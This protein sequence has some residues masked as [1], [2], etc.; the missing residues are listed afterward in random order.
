MPPDRCVEFIVDLIPGTTPI[1]RRPYR[2]APHELGELKTQLKVLLDKGLICPSSS[3]CGFPVLIVT[4]KDRTERM[5]VE[6]PRLNLAT[7]KSKYPLPRINDLYDQ[8]AGS[9]VF[10]KMDLRLGYHQIK[11]R[12]EDI[13]KTA[14]TTRYGLYEY[15]VMSFGLTNAP[16]TF[17]RL[18]NSIFMEYQDKFVVVYLD[19]ILIYSKN[20]EEHAEHLRLVLMKL[21]EHRLYAKF[22]KCEFWLPEVTYLGHVISAKAFAVNPERVQAV[23]DWTPPESVKQV[24]SFLGL[25]SYCRH[26]VENFSKVAK[27]LTELLQ[28]DKKFQW[29]PKREERFQELKRRLTSAPV[30]APPDTKWDF[31]IYCDSSRQGLGC[32]IMQDR[33]VVAYASRQLRPHEENYRTHDLELAVVVHALKTW[34][35][36]LLGNHCEIYSDHQ[37]LKYIF[38][39]PELNLR[40]RHWIELI[41]DYDVGISY[42]PG[43]ANVMADALSRKSYCNNLMLQQYQP[44]LHEE[45]RKRNLEIVPHGYLSTL[46]AKPTLEDQIIVAQRRARGVRRI[47][48]NIVSGVAK[49]FSTNSKGTVFFGNRL[50]VP[51]NRDLRQLILQEAHDTPLSIHPGSK[52]MYRD[53]RQR[54]WWTRMKRDI[55]RFV[56]ECDVCRRIKAEYQRPAGTLQPL[57]IPEWKWD[58]V[59]IDFITGFPKTQKGND[60][61]FVV[62]DRLS[63]VAHFLP[64]HESINA[65]QLAVLYVSRVVSLHGV[66]LEIN[67]DRGSLFTS[68]FWQSFQNAMG[69]HISF[70]TTFHPQSSGQVE[71][72]NQILDDMLRACV[73]SFGKNWEKSLPFAEFAYNNSYQASLG[74]APF[75]VLYGRKCRTPLNWSET[76]ERQ[77]FGPDM[78]QEA[79]EQ[80]RIIRENLKTAQSRQKSQYDRRHKEVAYEVG[81]KAYLRVTPLKGTH[82]FGIKGKMAPRYIGPFLILAKRGQVAYQLELPPHLSRVHDVFHVSQLRRCFK[83]PIREVD[84]ETLDLQDD[85]SYRGY[86]IRILDSAKSVTQRKKIKFLKVQ[87]SH[88]SEKEATWEREDCLRSEYPTFLPTT[89]ESKHE[90]LL[91]GG[92]LSQPQVRYVLR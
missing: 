67:S 69:T 43:K 62:I 54:F 72:V 70:S 22:S 81:D 90:I 20:E 47:K 76:G 17:S 34:R 11:I 27:P 30:L 73:I 5:C 25:E 61:I 74:K 21:R 29:T 26:F 16:A 80:V 92:E 15:T 14:F 49:C 57:P 39:Q 91:S 71:R 42:T 12:N 23:L 60:A 2:M 58:K 84:H 8:L 82:R 77:F 79:E 36:Y 10:S 1:S 38:T 83:D 87:W 78:I 32:I 46:V 56:A 9:S 66:P 18:M 59:S 37:S 4:K 85:L 53:L 50:V 64:I 55:A 3:P 13:P 19:D 65:S 24:R 86:P 89:S 75:E 7:I 41:K 48:E 45:F 51:K 44:L 40:Q 31:E 68:R 6:Y 88:H 52:K 28:K 63:K 35:H 33:H